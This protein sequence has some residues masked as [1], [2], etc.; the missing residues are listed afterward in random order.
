[1]N[2]AAGLR[3]RCAAWWE[4]HAATL[5]PSGQSML[6]SAASLVALAISGP[7]VARQLGVAGRGNLAFVMVWGL[8]FA[9]VGTLGV[10]AAIPYFFAR[11]PSHGKALL[12]EI[13]PIAAAQIAL[14]TLLTFLIL[15]LLAAGRPATVQL[16]AHLAPIYIPAGIVHQYALSILQARRRFAAF[17]VFRPLPGIL[18]AVAV[19][20]LFLTREGRLLPV[21]VAWLATSWLAATIAATVAL[22]GIGRAWRIA[23]KVRGELLRFALRGFVGS[24]SAVDQLSVDQAAVSVVLP[25]SSVGLYAVASAFSN[26]PSFVGWGLGTVIYPL[27]TGQRQRAAAR[28]T[29]RRFV[30][31]AFLLNVLGVG[32]L[33]A[34]LPALVR[35]FFGAPFL[36]AVPIARLLLVAAV[37]GASWRVL[38]EGLRGLGHPLVSSV[39]EAAMYP[40]LALT[41]P[42]L[43]FAWGAAGMALALVLSRGFSLGIAL[44]SAYVLGKRERTVRQRSSATAT[45]IPVVGVAGSGETHA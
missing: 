25:A 8:A 44:L 37:F 24:F 12:G 1:M 36:A 7:L 42:I 9:I 29:I 16:A 21:V 10:P 39:S 4:R 18:Y 2:G 26:L 28:S 38:V 34:L 20:A 15:A 33:L 13:F 17:N 35:F 22:R 31:W 23:S 19:L 14:A 41:A 11:D 43:I 27:V 32:T 40:L 6:A 5:V 3:M 45:A 30:V